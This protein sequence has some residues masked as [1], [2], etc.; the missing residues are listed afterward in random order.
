M[1]TAR[2]LKPWRRRYSGR[3]SRCRRRGCCGHRRQC[4]SCSGRWRR[5]YARHEG[6]GESLAGADGRGERQEP[7][8]RPLDRFSP[9]GAA[10]SLLDAGR[11]LHQRG[12]PGMEHAAADADVPF[13][14]Q[15]VDGPA[16]EHMGVGGAGNPA[17]AVQHDFAGIACARGQRLDR[18][19]VEMGGEDVDIAAGGEA[20]L[21]V[22]AA[23]LI[24]VAGRSDRQYFLTWS[25]E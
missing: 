7:E 4:G 23:L 2:G 6:G 9:A 8:R 1:T 3:G 15:V 12:V 14:G 18:L 22:V 20:G 19:V 16:A 5:R 11:G 10:P 13:A 24:L 17:G 21:A 25:E